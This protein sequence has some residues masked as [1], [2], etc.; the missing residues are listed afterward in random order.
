VLYVSTIDGSQWTYN[1][2]AYISAPVSSDWKTTGNASTVQATNFI[3]TTDNVGLSFRTNNVIR[4]TIDNAGNIGIGTTTPF[5]KLQVA[6][7]SQNAS[8]NA[9]NANIAVFGQPGV[10]GSALGIGYDLASNESW[11]STLAPNIAWRPLRFHGSSW[12]FVVSGNTE[13]FSIANNNNVGVN[14]PSPVSRLDV[15][16]SQSSTLFSTAVSMTLS[17]Q[18]FIIVTAASVL[19]LPTASTCLGRTYTINARSIGVT[20]SSYRDL[21]GSVQVTIPI[22]TSITIVS[23]G[24]NWQRID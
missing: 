8:P 21:S 16:G 11:I 5:G 2:T 14:R 15:N 20:I 24:T 1:G 9:W 18:R 13:T 23:D 10:G 4:Q 19:T 6:L 17:E 12:K 7:S 22:S 3:G